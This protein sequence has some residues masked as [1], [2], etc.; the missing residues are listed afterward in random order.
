MGRERDKLWGSL[1]HGYSCPRMQVLR[2]S[3]AR[4]SWEPLACECFGWVSEPGGLFWGPR[5]TPECKLVTQLD[6][7][8]Q[9][10]QVS[11]FPSSM[12]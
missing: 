3:R 11:F 12:E 4:L 6:M 8:F 2:C 7:A 10:A 5:R 9:A 1:A